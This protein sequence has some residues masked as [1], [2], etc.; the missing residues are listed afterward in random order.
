MLPGV[1]GQCLETFMVIT[2]VG[3]GGGVAIGIYWVESMDAAE[4]ST[5]HSAAPT[6]NYQAPDTSVSRLRK[7]AINPELKYGNLGGL[8][9]RLG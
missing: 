6:T 3:T 9:L 1:V 4:Y 5:M 7:P 8:M 2:L